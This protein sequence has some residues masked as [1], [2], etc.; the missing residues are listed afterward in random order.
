MHLAERGVE[1]CSWLVVPNKAKVLI[2]YL[3]KGGYH[4]R[5]FALFNLK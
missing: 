4:F 3:F 5:F 1:G 2:A